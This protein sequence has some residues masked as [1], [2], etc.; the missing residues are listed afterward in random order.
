M[1]KKKTL[2]T[3][4]KQ[5]QAFRDK[6]AEAGCTVQATVTALFEQGALHKLLI[7][8]DAKQPTGVVVV[9]WPEDGYQLYVEVPSIAIE[10]DIQAILDAD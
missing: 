5:Y 4:S 7:F 3:R 8:R 6:L 10:R 1:T 2:Y 9:D